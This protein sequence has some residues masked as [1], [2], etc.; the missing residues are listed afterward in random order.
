M[1]VLTALIILAQHVIMVL[2]LWVKD[3]HGL[4][5]QEVAAT[6]AMM[7]LAAYA[8]MMVFVILLKHIQHVLR[9]V[10][11]LTALLKLIQY[12]IQNATPIVE[13]SIHSAMER[14]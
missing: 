6:R 12:A 3:L 8:I 9:I 2:A 14:R 1:H 7:M 4:V 13:L 11:I 10:V 5:L